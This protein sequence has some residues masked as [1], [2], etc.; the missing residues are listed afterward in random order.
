MKTL[1]KC[2]L[3]P[4]STLLLALLMGVGADRVQAQTQKQTVNPYQIWY[5]TKAIGTGTIT[6]TYP[7]DEGDSFRALRSNGDLLESSP[8]SLEK[9]ITFPSRGLSIATNTVNS[10]I[11]TYG[12]GMPHLPMTWGKNCE[13][14]GAD[15]TGATKTILGFTTLQ[16][17]HKGTQR[18]KDGAHNLDETDESWLAPALNC[19]PLEE[20]STWIY[21]GAPDAVTTKIATAAIAGEPPDS[22]FELPS[23]PVEVHPSVFYESIG[24]KVGN[25]RQEYA[26]NRDRAKRADA[27]IR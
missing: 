16:I 25:P 27:G 20:T 1:L 15:L 14:Y 4:S 22:L 26:Y 8:S 6:R 10:N 9:F 11:S 21:N 5:H 24:Q 18:S 19:E 17:V 23:H 13:N 12:T 7:T 3:T 2:A